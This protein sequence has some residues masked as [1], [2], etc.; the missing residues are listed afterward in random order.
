MAY[1][2]EVR[3]QSDKDANNLA[4]MIAQLVESATGDR[5]TV[6]VMDRR[7]TNKN[8]QKEMDHRQRKLLQK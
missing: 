7:K 4:N 8:N 6:S 5:C 3:I 1:N 2:V